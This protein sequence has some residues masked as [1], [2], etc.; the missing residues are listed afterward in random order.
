MIIEFGQ[1]LQQG[2]RFQLQRVQAQGIVFRRHGFNS[3]RVSENL[4]A[5]AGVSGVFHS[6]T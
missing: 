5:Q 1:G 4:T 3:E 2:Q 6:F